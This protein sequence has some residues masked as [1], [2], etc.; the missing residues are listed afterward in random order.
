MHYEIIIGLI[1]GIMILLIVFSWIFKEYLSAEELDREICRQSIVARNAMPEEDLYAAV[2]SMKDSVELK[3]KTQVVNINYEDIK[4]AE[5]D[6]ADTALQCWS[7]VGRG[8]DRP[9]PTSQRFSSKSPCLPCARIHIDDNVKDYYIKNKINF[10]RALNFNFVDK[11]SYW[12]IL[13]PEDKIKAFEYFNGWGK[14]LEI[15][16]DY[17]LVSA[18]DTEA[19][20]YYP[21]T[22]NADSG[23]VLIF[24]SYPTRR[25]NYVKPYMLFFQDSDYEKIK[26]DWWVSY[27]GVRIPVCSSIEGIPA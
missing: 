12:E 27:Q 16:T 6:F 17:N 18:E 5:K 13:N 1:L 14:S 25:E 7:L 23:D 2:I 8:E 15:E 3:C 21:E 9:F 26:N 10:S 20:F 22:F 4:K 11:K 19:G 24:I